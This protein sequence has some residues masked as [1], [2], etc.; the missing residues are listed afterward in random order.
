MSKAEKVCLDGQTATGREIEGKIAST[1]NW[2][3]SPKITQICKLICLKTCSL[4]VV[5]SA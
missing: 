3:M 2:F 4:V 5:Y 1:V